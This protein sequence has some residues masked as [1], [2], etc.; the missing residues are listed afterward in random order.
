MDAEWGL[1]FDLKVPL[2]GVCEIIYGLFGLLL[3]VNM[4][5]EFLTEHAWYRYFLSVILIMGYIVL[6][7]RRAWAGAKE[8]GR[9]CRPISGRNADRGRWPYIPGGCDAAAI[10]EELDHSTVANFATVQ[11]EG[12]QMASVKYPVP[13]LLQCINSETKTSRR[14]NWRSGI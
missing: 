10:K 9:N 2:C 4:A 13:F 6:E 5:A 11:M 14:K 8:C 7:N 3:I 12:G 1:P